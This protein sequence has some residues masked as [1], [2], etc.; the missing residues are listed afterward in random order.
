MTDCESPG[1]FLLAFEPDRVSTTQEHSKTQRIRALHP[2]VPAATGE[3]DGALG[4]V[5]L[6]CPCPST[7]SCAR[8]SERLL[9][10]PVD[11]AMLTIVVVRKL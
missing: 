8:S 11:V 7:G 1:M 5:A 6:P 3:P 9:R 2:A 4:I 10:G